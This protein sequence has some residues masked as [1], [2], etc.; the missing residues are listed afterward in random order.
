MKEFKIYRIILQ[1]TT[2]V[3]SFLLGS[4]YMYIFYEKGDF[5]LI[6]AC[7]C[8]LIGVAIG[9][10]GSEIDTFL[11]SRAEERRKYVINEVYKSLGNK[12]GPR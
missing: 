3:L 11:I 4:L 10:V 7:A 1:V 9:L 6:H 5:L 2:F 8:V 12:Y